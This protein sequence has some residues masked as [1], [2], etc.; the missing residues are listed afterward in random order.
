MTYKWSGPLLTQH[1]LLRTKKSMS[2]LGYNTKYPDSDSKS[3]HPKYDWI[4]INSNHRKNWRNPN[5]VLLHI[6]DYNTQ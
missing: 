3:G 5:A 6:Y 1:L 2:T 4:L